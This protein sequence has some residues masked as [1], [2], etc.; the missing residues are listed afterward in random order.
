MTDLE[1]LKAMF[2][3]A[4][5]PYTEI[6][7]GHWSTEL[8]EPFDPILDLHALEVERTAESPDTVVGY[9]G[10]STTYYFN[11]DGSLRAV[12]SWE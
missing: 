8:Q 4:K 7:A 9:V 1:T 3:R 2:N 6:P 12:G 11:E 5:I 10:F